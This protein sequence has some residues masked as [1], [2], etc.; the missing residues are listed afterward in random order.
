MAF[1][2][3]KQSDYAVFVA[4]AKRATRIFAIGNMILSGISE[5]KKDVSHTLLANPTGVNG[6]TVKKI[7]PFR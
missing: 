6:C 5:K 3:Q 4:L 1:R 2:Y 7:Q